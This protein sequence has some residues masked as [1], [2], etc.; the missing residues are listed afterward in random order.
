MHAVIKEIKEH[1]NLI[2]FVDEAHTLVGAGSAIGAPADA[3]NI[4][5]SGLARGEVRMIGATTMSEDKSYIQ[6]DEALARRFRTVVVPEPTLDDTRHILNGLKPRLERLY[7]VRLLEKRW[8]PRWSWRRA[9]NGTCT[10]PTRR[11]A[12][13]TRP[14]CA[15]KW[16]A[17]G[18]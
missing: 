15:P 8:K 1:P 11:S 16:I 18:T 2:L 14:P 17:A 9:T 5:K 7:S 10:C 4:F 6:E 3:A 12:G 13:W